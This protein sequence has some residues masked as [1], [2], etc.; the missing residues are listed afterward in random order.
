MTNPN[1][2]ERLQILGTFA[3]TFAGKQSKKNCF[4]IF[5]PFKFV[6]IEEQIKYHLKHL[7]S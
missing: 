4:F 5:S 3:G 2:W 6:T 1:H 7:G